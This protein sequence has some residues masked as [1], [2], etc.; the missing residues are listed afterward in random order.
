MTGEYHDRLYVA[1]SL[2][3]SQSSLYWPYLMDR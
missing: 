3:L 1:L 2:V